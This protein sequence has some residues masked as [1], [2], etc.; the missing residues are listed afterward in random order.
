MEKGTLGRS[1]FWDKLS[2]TGEDRKYTLL[3]EGRVGIDP[4]ETLAR[5]KRRKTGSTQ[6]FRSMAPKELST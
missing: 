2:E 4:Y 3:S 5:E 1:D 6:D